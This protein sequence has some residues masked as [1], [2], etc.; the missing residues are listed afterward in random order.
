VVEFPSTPEAS[1]FITTDDGMPDIPESMMGVGGLRALHSVGAE[2][3]LKVG[4]N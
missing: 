4:A 2:K 3:V 1:S